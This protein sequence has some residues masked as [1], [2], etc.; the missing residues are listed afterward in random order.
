MLRGVFQIIIL[1]SL[2]VALILITGI[3]D[4]MAYG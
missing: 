1:K 4:G 2:G 3:V